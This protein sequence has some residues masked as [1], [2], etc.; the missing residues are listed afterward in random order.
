MG[1]SH[2]AIAA[3]K[4]RQ[5]YRFRRGKRRVP[6]RPMLHRAR[7]FALVVDVFPRLLTADQGLARGRMLAL[8]ESGELLLVDL[9]A[10]SVTRGKLAL[11]P[12]PHALA[13]RVIVLLSVRE[14]RL[15]IRL[16]LAR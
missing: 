2:A 5:R 16:R 1:L 4:S 3:N 14:L 12:T 11:L 13:F 8:R 6:P 7:R 15:V 9:A 10:Q